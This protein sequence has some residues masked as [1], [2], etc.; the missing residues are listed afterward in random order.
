[1]FESLLKI[2]EAGLSIWDTAQSRKYKKSVLDLKR[3]RAKELEKEFPD[4]DVVDK[5]ERQLQWLAELFASEIK[6]QKTK[7][8]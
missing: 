2:F 3:K 8:L 7:D 4:Y 6:G 5:C 1:M